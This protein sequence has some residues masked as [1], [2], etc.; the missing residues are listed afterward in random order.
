[1]I[2]RHVQAQFVRV[3]ACASLVGLAYECQ[4]PRARQDH[5]CYPR[6][7][8][9]WAHDCRL[10]GKDTARVPAVHQ[11]TRAG[12]PLQAKDT[13]V[14]GKWAFEQHSGDGAVGTE[15][16]SSVGGMTCSDLG[17]DNGNDVGGADWPP[18]NRLYGPAKA[19]GNG[20]ASLGVLP[21]SHTGVA[22]ASSLVLMLLGFFSLRPRSRAPTRNAV[23]RTQL[24]SSIRLRPRARTQPVAKAVA[25]A[26]RA[27]RC[28]TLGAGQKRGRGHPSLPAEVSAWLDSTERD[29]DPQRDNWCMVHSV[30]NLLGFELVSPPA[31]PVLRVSIID[32]ESK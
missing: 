24:A 11:P 17:D 9:P 20:A 22:P 13:T 16:A 3:C 30:N 15:G 10:H 29:F 1:M 25:P 8:P 12:G 5:A 28:L 19:L 32:R 6:V 23:A 31:L 21:D 26:E 4:Q 18:S 27:V 2:A 14:P 7:L